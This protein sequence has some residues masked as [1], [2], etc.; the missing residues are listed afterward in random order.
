MM[1]RRQNKWL[2]E[3]TILDHYSSLRDTLSFSVQVWRVRVIWKACSCFLLG[4]Y[5]Q[6]ITKTTHVW[7]FVID[8]HSPYNR[9]IRV[10]SRQPIMVHNI[11]F[12]LNIKLD[13]FSIF[14]CGDYENILTLTICFGKLHLLFV[15][16]N[17]NARCP[18]DLAWR[19]ARVQMLV[20]VAPNVARPL[21]RRLSCHALIVWWAVCHIWPAMLWLNAH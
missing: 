18:K 10:T 15:W 5:T 13:D 21:L 12:L 9:I 14:L 11:D 6:A 4:Y 16:R 3:V 7:I 19:V 20:N 8:L 17:E 2:V 1:K